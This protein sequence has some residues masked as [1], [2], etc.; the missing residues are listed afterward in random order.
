MIKVQLW[1]VMLMVLCA[2]LIDKIYLGCLDVLHEFRD[3]I[4]LLKVIQKNKESMSF[5][6]LQIVTHN[7][8]WLHICSRVL[9]TKYEIL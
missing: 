2:Y 7:C 3:M 9:Q 6:N 5:C 1:F 8:V 4:V